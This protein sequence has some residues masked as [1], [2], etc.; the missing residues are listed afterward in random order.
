MFKFTPLSSFAGASSSYNVVTRDQCYEE[1][2]AYL[3][4]LGLDKDYN[5]LLSNGLNT[6]QLREMCRYAAVAV[7]Y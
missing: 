3:E 2:A 5:Y 7:T 1:T 6:E 4:S